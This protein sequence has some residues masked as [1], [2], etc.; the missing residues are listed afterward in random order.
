MAVGC[1]NK[2]PGPARHVHQIFP[3]EFSS[4][5][6]IIELHRCVNWKLYEI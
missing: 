4:G 5:N 1:E 6:P 3:A 2:Y